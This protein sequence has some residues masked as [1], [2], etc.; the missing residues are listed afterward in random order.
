MNTVWQV[1][2]GGAIPSVNP[3]GVMRHEGMMIYALL[4]VLNNY[5]N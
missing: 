3:Y 1:V 4:T 2:I 5:D